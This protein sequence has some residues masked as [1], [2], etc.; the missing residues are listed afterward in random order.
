MEGNQEISAPRYAAFLAGLATVR[1]SIKD[2][3]LLLPSTEIV[4][5]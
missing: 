4:Y 5:R 1:S 3:D 2:H